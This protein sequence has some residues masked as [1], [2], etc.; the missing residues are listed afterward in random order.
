MARIKLVL[1]EGETVI[2][3]CAAAASAAG[4]GVAWFRDFIERAEKCVDLDQMLHLVL[5]EFDVRLEERI[6]D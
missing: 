2:N 6:P 1:H 5:R 3:Q 4:L